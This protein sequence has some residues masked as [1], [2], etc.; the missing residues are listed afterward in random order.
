MVEKKLNSFR[1]I[2][3][4]V[5]VEYPSFILSFHCPNGEVNRDGSRLQ[6]VELYTWVVSEPKIRLIKKAHV[7]AFTN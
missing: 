1:F 7:K 6:G 4:W 3:D 5:D 2:Y